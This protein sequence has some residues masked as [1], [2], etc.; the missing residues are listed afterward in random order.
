M[1]DLLHPRA[2][3]IDMATGRV[4]AGAEL[5]DLVDAAA[6]QFAADTARRWVAGQP[7]G[8]VLALTAPDA[9]AVA[10][11][12]GALTAGRAVALLD[13][14]SIRPDLLHLIDRF[15]PA[16]VTGVETGTGLTGQAAPDGYRDA[17]LPGLGRY[18]VRTAPG[19]TEPHPDMAVLLHTDGRTGSPTLLELSRAALH[20]NAESLAR[21][22]D[23]GVTTVA[24]A[25]PA[26]FTPYGLSILNAHLL[27]GATV[28][29][30][31]PGRHAEAQS[32]AA[33]GV[34]VRV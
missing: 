11:Y 13:P 19:R 10:R 8:M 14:A 30:D 15:A 24:S 20:D 21:R 33:A 5:A 16:L 9:P 12:L 25:P 7:A 26:L 3:L 31:R 34:P 28:V 32:R 6:E 18:W 22:L 23:I 1:S 27:R 29:L 4:V 2:R 17:T